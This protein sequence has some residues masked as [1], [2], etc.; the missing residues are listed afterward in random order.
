MDGAIEVVGTR[1]IEWPDGLTAAIH[2]EHPCLLLP[3]YGVTL[4]MPTAPLP[5]SENE[6]VKNGYRPA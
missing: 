1:C 2:T 3:G 6:W 4:R 5:T